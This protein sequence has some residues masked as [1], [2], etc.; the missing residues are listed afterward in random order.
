MS[1]ARP[2]VRI[3][4]A[5]VR[6]A[7]TTLYSLLI[8]AFVLLRVFGLKAAAPALSVLTIA[9]ILVSLPALSRIALGLSLLFLV[10]GTAMLWS[11]GITFTG[12]VGAYGQM[13]HLVALF[14]LVPILA[15]PVR[16]GGYGDAISTVL[17]GRVGSLS[18]LNMLITSLAY[19]CGSFMTMAAIPIMIS[20]LRP[21]VE[22][23]PLR[24]RVHFIATSTTCGH[25]MSLL[26]SPVS[27]V[28][29]AILTGL[30]VSWFDVVPV[31]V[32][33]SIVILVVNWLL[34]RLLEKGSGEP[35]PPV[36]DAPTPIQLVQARNRLL[37]LGLVIVMLVF[38]M[39]GLE[40]LLH[41]GL[42]TV[43]VIACIPFTLAWSLL[44]GQARPFVR[45][46]L[47]DMS[48]RMPRMAEMFAIFLCGGFFASALN[49]SGYVHEANVGLLALREM[50]GPRPFLMALPLVALM[51]SMVGLHPLVA[52]AILAEALKPEVLGIAPH[53]LAIAL[54]GGA[55]LTYM[56]GPF[57]GTLGLVSTF[58]NMSTWRLSWW[59]LPYGIS[60]LLLL[61][62][63]LW[64][65]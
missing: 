24:D 53:H 48:V 44:I 21:V 39:V 65:M 25:L 4:D 47:H 5:A 33:L 2:S 54:T 27:G 57:G 56:L 13:A 23:Y 62:G 14:C 15:I 64:L 46:T 60:Y 59:N 37:Q 55:L 8:I 50:L 3:P 49:L 51:G 32:P 38:V 1:L 42:V 18:R 11:T 17:R 12:Y 58:T 19:V 28:L 6:R 36:A 9:S 45:T 7:R 52:M 31:M 61:M 30:R 63:A 16:L 35:L 41:L 40:Q 34:F 43:V 10:S 29:A 22:R 26:W 20:S